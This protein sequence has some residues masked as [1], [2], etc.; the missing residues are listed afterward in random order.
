[1]IG[2][3][4]EFSHAMLKCRLA[5]QAIVSL[6]KSMKMVTETEHKA[7]LAESEQWKEKLR[8]YRSVL[9]DLRDKLYTHAAGKADADF[10]KEV[11]H[12]HNQFHIQL[13]NIHDLK[14]AIKHHVVEADH[15]PNF[16]HR[17]PHHNLEL[18]FHQLIEDL[19]KLKNDFQN[20]LSSR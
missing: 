17:I 1:M 2:L 9:N 6:L 15:H 11:E 8:A 12:Y 10:L 13:I 7:L 4:G 20:F 19:D 16:G 18:Q 5:K 3:Q 14:H